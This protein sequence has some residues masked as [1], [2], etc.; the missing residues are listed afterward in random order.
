M[1]TSIIFYFSAITLL[2]VSFAKDKA[3]TR[4]AMMKAYKSFS[5]LMPALFP[6]VLI[7]GFLL[8][9]IS[10]ELIGNILGKDSGIIGILVGLVVG[11]FAFIPGFVAFPLG[12]TLIENGA[13]Y[14]QVAAFLSAA[15]AVGVASLAVEIQYFDKKMA[16]IRNIIAVIGSLLFAIIIGLVM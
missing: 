13:G 7:V 14:A 2:F 11:S 6:L 3:K 10:P 8:T 12:G 1:F 16:F 9:Y 15:M 4:K 5:N